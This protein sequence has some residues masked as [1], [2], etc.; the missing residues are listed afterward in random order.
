MAAR[1]YTKIR[2]EDIQSELMTILKAKGGPLADLSD[3]SYGRILL[4]LFAGTEDLMA[5][6]AKFIF[7]CEKFVIFH[8]YLYLRVLRQSGHLS[9]TFPKPFQQYLQ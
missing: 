1:K 5:Y 3:S 7:I 2:F 4:D 6:Y 9:P 8:I